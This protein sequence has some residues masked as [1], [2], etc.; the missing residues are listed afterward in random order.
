MNNEIVYGFTETP[1]GTIIVARTIVGICDVAFLSW[2]R[3]AVIKEL[4]THWGTYTPTTQNNVM[5]DTVRRVIFEGYD[6]PLTLDL[7]G[8]PFQRKVCQTLMQNQRGETLSYEALAL[9]AGEPKAIRAVA[10]AVAQNRVA[11]LVP[12]HRV[13]HKD[14]TLGEYHWGKTLKQ[15]LLDW[16]KN[17]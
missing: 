10:S 9:R 17:A 15:Q 14:G 8:T 3:A 12:C 1:F 16:E 6:H 7:Q 5:A 13:I 11:M 2:N 4:A